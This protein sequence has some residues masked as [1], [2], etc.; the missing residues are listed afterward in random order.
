MKRHEIHHIT[1]LLALDEAEFARMLPDL[2][3]W[4]KAAKSLQGIEGVEHKGFV[5]IDDGIVGIDHYQATDPKTGA[6]TTYS[7]SAKGADHA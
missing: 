7:L 5:W 1:D 6:V 4:W 3:V 2:C